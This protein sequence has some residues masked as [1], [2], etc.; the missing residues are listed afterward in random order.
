VCQAQYLDNGDGTVTD[1]KTG[2]V[3]E[4]KTGTVG[5]ANPTD[6]HDVSNPYS[7]TAT[8]LIPDG[9]LYTDF[10]ATL[11]SNSTNDATSVCF[12]NHCDWR[13]PTIVELQTIIDS[14][15]SGCGSGAPCINSAFGPTLT[16]FYWSS[17]SLAPNPGDT[18]FVAAGDEDFR[19]WH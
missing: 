19:L 11:N 7:W 16:S 2:L 12:A 14:T 18:R 10:L 17:S 5:T 1:N 15:A 6:V 4:K 13:I 3:W 9:T 8:G